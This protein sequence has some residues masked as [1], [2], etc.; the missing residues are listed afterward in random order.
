MPE[1]VKDPTPA[2]APAPAPAPEKDYKAIFEEAVQSRDAAKSKMREYEA[3]IAR[4]RQ[5]ETERAAREAQ[6][7]EEQERSKIT[8]TSKAQD[9]IKQQELKWQSEKDSI[10]K[11]IHEKYVPTAIKA[12]ASKIKGLT[13]EAVEDLPSLVSSR[14]K[15]D[16]KTFE[17]YVADEKGEPLK[18]EKLNPV[19]VESFIEQ[20]TKPR[21]YMFV[22]A[23]PKGTGATST[24]SGKAF[25]MEAALND[26]KLDMEWK[27]LDPAGY[28]AAL[29]AY[30]KEAP[31]RAREKALSM[32][33]PVS[34]RTHR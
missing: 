16:P 13:P 23:M 27:K 14:I 29:A 15:I 31:A 24:T 26:R 20:F 32:V 22:D 25:T 10:Y 3:E 4:Y 7:K 19:S 33:S 1:T 12:A 5:A 11:T 34:V 8:E 6:A 28:Q 30:R 9:Y 18:D 17:T 21:T 2:S